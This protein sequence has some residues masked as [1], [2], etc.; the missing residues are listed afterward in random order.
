MK[1]KEVLCLLL[2]LINLQI[3]WSEKKKER[4]K[5][6]SRKESTTDDKKD[7]KQKGEREERPKDKGGICLERSKKLEIQEPDR[8]MIEKWVKVIWVYDVDR[9]KIEL[10]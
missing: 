4:V 6:D 10:N 5:R 3:G 2:K 8:A 1:E 7:V 9:V